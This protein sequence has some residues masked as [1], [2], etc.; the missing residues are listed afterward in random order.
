M[1]VTIMGGWVKW[2]KNVTNGIKV[3]LCVLLRET[4]SRMLSLEKRLNV[5]PLDKSYVNKA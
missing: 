1:G 2:T 5:T 4:S 3:T